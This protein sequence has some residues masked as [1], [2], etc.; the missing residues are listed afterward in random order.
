MLGR[1]IGRIHYRL[2]HSGLQPTIKGLL[3]NPPPVNTNIK[4]SG[5]INSVRYAKNVIFLDV[6]DGSDARSLY[7]VLKEQDKLG[8]TKFKRGQS[9]SVEGKWIESPGKQDYELSYTPS[10]PEHKL[11]ILGDIEETY[12]IQK[13]NNL[14]PIMRTV[15]ALRHRIPLLSS[16]L[17][18][19]SFIESELY[20]FFNEHDFTKV[21][22]PIITGSDCEG[23]GETFKVERMRIDEEEPDFKFFGRDANLTVSTQLHLEVLALSL[24]RA[25]SLGPCFRAEDS[26]TNRHLCEFWMLEAEMCYV[27]DLEQLMAFTELMIRRVTQKLHDNPEDV[28]KGRYQGEAMHYRWRQ[29]LA[30]KPWPRITYAEARDIINEKMIQ[31]RIKGSVRWGYSISSMQEKWLAGEYFK[32]PVFITDYPSEIKP[33]YMPKSANCDPEQPTVACYDLILP[34]M[35][36]LVGGSLREY[37]Y[38]KLLA[39]MQ[40]RNMNTEEMDWYLMTRRNGSMPHGGFGMGIDRLVTFL[41]CMENIKDVVAFPRHP[42]ECRC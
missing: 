41:S 6:G 35:G 33:F 17:R 29:I 28:L 12:P 1:A 3:T 25:W 18:L 40:A 20:Q 36:E 11:E 14:L 26:N 31:G 38:D 27:D 32:S 24:N 5:H 23:A 16:I 21:T 42:D 19:R 30:K 13:K 9:V 2:L 8:L 4:A 39:E 7:I 34:E 10:D 37:D 22:P 15:P